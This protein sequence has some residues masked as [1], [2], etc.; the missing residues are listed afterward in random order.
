MKKTWSVP[1]FLFISLHAQA[2][3]VLDPEL[4]VTYAGPCKDGFAEGIGTA[5]GSAEYRGGFKAGRKHGAGVKTWPNG[6]R[7]EGE[8][9]EDRREGHG[10]YRFGRGPWAGERY[11]GDFLNDRR[12]GY[13]VY[14]WPT[15]DVYRG[16]WKEDIA[17]GPPTPMMQA[18]ARYERQ[19]RAAV[20]KPGRK[21]CREAHIGIAMREWQPG[22]V[23]GLAGDELSVRV[24]DRIVRTKPQDW[25]PCW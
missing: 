16:P 2:C 5:A 22:V 3:G 13:G 17:I 11:D 9:V 14:R 6:D 21:V 15:G 23:V 19:A 20:G 12:H 8:F 7:Y 24:G 4:Q 25:T 18:R 10:I 1:V